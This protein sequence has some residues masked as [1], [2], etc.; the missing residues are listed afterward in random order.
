M[1]VWVINAAYGMGSRPVQDQDD[2]GRWLIGD[3]HSPK[4]VP[5]TAPSQKYYQSRTLGTHRGHPKGLRSPPIPPS[6]VN[7]VSGQ[8]IYRFAAAARR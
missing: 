4:V 5:N 8:R 1:V 2:R 7:P 6:H 3:A